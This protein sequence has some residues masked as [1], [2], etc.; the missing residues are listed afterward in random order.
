MKFKIAIWFG[1]TCLRGAFIFGAEEVGAVPAAESQ[2][3]GELERN[4]QTARWMMDYDQVAW[5]T[6]DLLLKESKDTLQRI[7]AVW[8]CVE[9]DAV[10]YA[11]Y[12]GY[13]SN[14]FDIALCYRQLAKGK[15]EKVSRP[16]LADKDRFARAL[17]LTLPE[18]QDITRRTAVRFNYYIRGERDRIMLYYLPAFQTDGKLAYGI[19]HVYELDATGEKLISHRQHGRILVGAA[20]DKNRTLTLEISDCAVPTP[21]ALFTMMSHREEFADIVT[22]CQNGYFGVVSRNG[23]FACIRISAPPPNPPPGGGAR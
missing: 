19:E 6:T 23:V 17:S 3:S 10:W 13:Q 4:L 14:A 16:D 5:G 12:G 2:A 9:Q 21:A 11:A 15:F 18:I 8:F 22:H 7:S 1:L 20:P